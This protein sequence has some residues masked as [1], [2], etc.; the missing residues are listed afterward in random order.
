MYSI[1]LPTYNERES[2]LATIKAIQQE[3]ENQPYEII[4]CDDNSPDKTTEL[5]EQAFKKDRRVKV[6]KRT[7]KKKGLSPSIIDGI[8]LAKGEWIIVMDADG[9]HPASVL[10]RLI[11]ETAKH[12]VVIASRFVKGG[13]VQG[14][15]KYRL[16]LSN[17]ASFLAQPVL[18]Q[19]VQD[20]MSGF[21]AVKKKVITSSPA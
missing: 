6:L 16:T 21:F 10:P 18:W 5:V 3:I 12:D 8:T 13:S 2:V 7:N 14:W 11:K 1:L 20:P 17:I 15:P 19:N 9:Q 4:I